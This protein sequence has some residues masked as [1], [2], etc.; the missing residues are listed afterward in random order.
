MS[1]SFV[2]ALRATF[3]YDQETG[4][5]WRRRSHGLVK[6]KASISSNGYARIGFDGKRYGAHRIAWAIST[7][8]WP[9]RDIDHINGVRTDNRIANLRHVSRATN[10]EN[11]RG[12]KSHNVSSG[13]LGVYITNKGCITSRIGVNGKSIYLGSFRTVEEARAAYISAK[14]QHHG[15]FVN[16]GN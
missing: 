9:T 15:G 2:A 16:V 6:Q 1:N 11:L 4:E 10:L 3:V 14:R 13:V 8:E 5:I 12:A 7:G